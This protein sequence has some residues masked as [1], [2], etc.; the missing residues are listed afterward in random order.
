MK[1]VLYVEDLTYTNE[2]LQ[3]NKSGFFHS[4][5]FITCI[6]V[7]FAGI[8]LII[9]KRETVV[10][11]KGLIRPEENISFVKSTV[12]G[13]IKEINFKHGQKVSVGDTLLVLDD[14]IFK[15][16]KLHIEEQLKKINKK[17]KDIDFCLKSINENTICVPRNRSVAYKQIENYFS[18]KHNLEKYVELNSEKLKEEKSLPQFS[19]SEYK[20]K[21]LTLNLEKSQSDL[22]QYINSFLHSLYSERENFQTQK[23]SLQTSLSKIK[24]EIKQLTICAAIEGDVQELSSLN[25]GDNIFTGQDVA[26]IIPNGN[27]NIMAVLYIPASHSGLIQE[28]MKVKLKFPAF[29]HYEFGSAQGNI[30]TILPDI[31]YSGNKTNEYVALVHID[32]KFLTDKNGNIHNLKIGLDIEASIITDTNSILSFILKRLELK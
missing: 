12:S 7:F 26:K 30:K 10:K 13:K 22:M 6:L 3:E 27:D 23:E 8:W 19:V 20:I 11:A 14:S 2:L 29:P 21:M 32:K 18:V 4:V 5:I 24:E 9:G 15:T 17:I 25:C 31:L 16:E 1:S 28:N